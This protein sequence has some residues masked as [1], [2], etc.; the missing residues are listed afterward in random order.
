MKLISA[1]FHPL[2]L[3]TYYFLVIYFIQPNLLSPIPVTV[4]PKLILVIFVA[5]CLLPA[6]CILLLKLT[7]NIG[8]LHLDKRSDRIIP[9]VIIAFI[10]AVITWFLI[11]R[12]VL[13][14]Q[15]ITTMGCITV[16]IG[17]L[18]I[19]TLKYKISIHAAAIWASAGILSALSIRYNL[20][21]FYVPT[22]FS[23]VIAGWVSSSR[24]VLRKHTTTEVWSVSFLGFL[25]C[26]IFIYFCP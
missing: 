13:S 14:T 26:F 18:C 7:R 1:I 20:M 9:F 17:V 5:S 22:L 3:C 2:I 19:I 8:S 10:Y 11:Q 12:L 16:L 15:V 6:S 24:L 23:F 4:A 25:S 21:A